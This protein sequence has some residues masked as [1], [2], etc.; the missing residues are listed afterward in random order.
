MHFQLHLQ[1]RLKLDQ[2]YLCSFQLNTIFHSSLTLSQLST[3]HYFLPL[4][5]LLEWLRA[6]SSLD[7]VAGNQHWSIWN[8]QISR[9]TNARCE[10]SLLS[11]KIEVSQLRYT[12]E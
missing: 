11:I 1:S 12:I 5:R 6:R 9:Q 7:D 8:F 3:N 2:W 10:F 4:V